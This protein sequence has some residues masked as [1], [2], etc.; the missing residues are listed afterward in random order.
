MKILILSE[1]QVYPCLSGGQIRTGS[2]A[3]ALAELGHDVT[4]YSFTGRKKDYLARRKS[5]ATMSPNGVNEFVDRRPFYGACQWMA[6][7]FQLPPLWS[8]LFAK[9]FTPKKLRR[10]PT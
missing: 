7:K 4:I 3:R 5:S 10:D 1:I 9:F 6:Y 2:F 8:N